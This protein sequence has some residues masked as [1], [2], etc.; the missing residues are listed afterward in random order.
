[1]GWIWFSAFDNSFAGI[2][3]KMNGETLILKGFE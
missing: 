1:M 2:L 3:F